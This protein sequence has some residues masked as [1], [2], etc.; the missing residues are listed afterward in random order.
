MIAVGGENLIDFVYASDVD[1]LPSYVAHP[2]GS[3][4]NVAMAAGRQDVDVTYMNP[5]SSDR[6]GDLLAERLLSSNVKLG[7]ARAEQP[8]SLAVVSLQDGIPSYGFYRDG[9]AER[10]ITRATL[11]T[12]LP[13]GTKIFHIGSGGLTGGVDAEIWEDFFNACKGAG[14]MV[15]LDP[16][17][18]PSLV[19]DETVYRARIKRMVANTDILKLSDEDL[20]WLYE[21]MDFAAAKAA[22]LADSGAAISVFTRGGDG[23]EGVCG[24]TDIHVPAAPVGTLVDTV[25]AGDTFMASMLVWMI[26]NDINDRGQLAAIDEASVRAMLTRAGKAAAINCGRAGC[27]PPTMAELG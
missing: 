5:I 9:T 23:A 14:I 8:S 11:D 10:Q 17:V 15:S 19:E 24:D 3:P 7:M 6:L 21:G 27:N 26:Q 4:F 16:N 13:Q 22:C 1:G 2:G 12:A 18:R 20:L 25:G